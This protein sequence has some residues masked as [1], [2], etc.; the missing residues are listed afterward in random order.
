MSQA[1]KHVKWC[2]NK[3]KKEI[4]ESKKL[5]KRIKHRG[6]LKVEP[7]IDNAGNHI[8]KAE[9]NLNA[10]SKFK[11]IGFS[12]WSIAA[13][14]YSIYH[15][16]L[17]IA[18]KFGYESRNQT[19]TI[20][21]IEWL[22]E[23]GKIDIDV[24]FIETLKETDIEELRECKVIEMREDYTYGINISIEDEAKIKSLRDTCIEIIDI[25]K[26]IVFEQSSGKNY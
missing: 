15:C 8:T 12:D 17:A 16:F 10:I 23:E 14:F 6:L 7:N 26:R 20:A 4:E 24:K 2:I 25:T 11:E 13:G 9:H 18:V 21:L 3:A 22:K 1:D 19:C 5:G